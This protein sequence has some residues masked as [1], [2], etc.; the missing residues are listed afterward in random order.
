MIVTTTSS[1]CSHKSWKGCALL[2][3]DN[4]TIIH[5][6]GLKTLKFI[7]VEGTMVTERETGE[8]DTMQRTEKM[9]NKVIKPVVVSVVGEEEE[10]GGGMERTKGEGEEIMSTG[11]VTMWMLR[12]KVNILVDRLIH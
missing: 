3:H 11:R 9:K 1:A 5:Y 6:L 4:H 2:L 7:I 8:E 12:I 10:V